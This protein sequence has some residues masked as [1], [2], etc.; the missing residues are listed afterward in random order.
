MNYKL[1]NSFLLLMILAGSARHLQA[2]NPI[3]RLRGLGNL[4]MGPGTDSL[5]HRTGYEDSITISY[6]YLD[7]SRYRRMDTSINDFSKRYPI[8]ADYIFLGNTGSAARSI[9][10]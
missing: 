3:G 5:Q 7:S 10:F 2:Q 4:R 1:F 8:P 9:L 6:R